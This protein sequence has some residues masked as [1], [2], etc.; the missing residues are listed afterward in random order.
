MFLL[1][2]INISYQES[3]IM[4]KDNVWSYQHVILDICLDYPKEQVNIS[5]VYYDSTHFS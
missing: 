3:R 4:A 1:Q 5:L 2:V